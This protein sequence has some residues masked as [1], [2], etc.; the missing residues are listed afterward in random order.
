[1]NAHDEIEGW[2]T[3]P[4]WGQAYRAEAHT[5]RVA[6][7][8]RTIVDTRGRVRRLPGREL[9]RC[10]PAGNVTLCWKGARRTFSADA[11]QRLIASAQ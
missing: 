11:I 10:G 7:K 9:R 8:A 1:M 6:S 2:V 4:G 5:G 3:L